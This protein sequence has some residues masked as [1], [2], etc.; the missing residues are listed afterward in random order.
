MLQSVAYCVLCVCVCIMIHTSSVLF[1]DKDVYRTDREVD[2]YKK[3]DS[4]SLV[5]LED[6]L[7]TYVIYNVDLGNN[8]IIMHDSVLQITII[9]QYAG[10]CFLGFQKT[11]FEI[12]AARTPN[13]H[14]LAV[15]IV[16]KN[17]N[18]GKLCSACNREVGF[19]ENKSINLI[20]QG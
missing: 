9:M 16:Q 14:S 12:C 2:M 19:R 17:G 4:F 5:Q 20:I 10:A 3:S 18:K 6:I 11:P 13:H 8:I 15:Q 1:T 7:T